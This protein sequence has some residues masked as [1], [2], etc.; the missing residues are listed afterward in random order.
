MKNVFQRTVNLDELK[1]KPLSDYTPEQ[2]VA[3]LTTYYKGDPK[4]AL[5]N[6]ERNHEIGFVLAD[7]TRL[8]LKGLKI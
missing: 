2:L 6:Y 3:Y 8:L 7:Q 5:S 1:D 4:G